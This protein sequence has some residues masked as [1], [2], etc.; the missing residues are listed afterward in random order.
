MCVH[1]H[2][3]HGI[4]DKLI[5]LSFAL[6]GELE[7]NTINCSEQMRLLFQICHYVTHSPAR[8]GKPKLEF[9]CLGLGRHKHRQF[10]GS[11]AAY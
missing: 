2:L 3:L 1:A 6:V 8:A 10:T 11:L 5:S 7:Q 9:I 4:F